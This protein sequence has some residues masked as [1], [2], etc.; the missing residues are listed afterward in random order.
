MKNF[1][2]ALGGKSHIARAVPEICPRCGQSMAGRVYH[3]YLGHLGLH[4]LADKYFEGD[5]AAAQ[6]R[7]RRNGLARQDPFE[8]NGAWPRYQPVQQTELDLA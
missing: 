1:V 5:L 6:E 3:S 8:G 7:L 2:H 4:G